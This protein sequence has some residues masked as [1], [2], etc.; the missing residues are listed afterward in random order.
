MGGIAHGGSDLY[1]FEK[2]H[3]RIS[4]KEL[5]NITIKKDIENSFEH[6]MLTEEQQEVIVELLKKERM[7]LFTSWLLNLLERCES[8]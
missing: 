2:L 1:G 5:P 7:P 6:N 4:N 8:R 3:F